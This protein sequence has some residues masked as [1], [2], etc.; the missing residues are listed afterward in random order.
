MK[1][2]F[3]VEFDQE[4]WDSLK[5]DSAQAGWVDDVRDAINEHAHVTDEKMCAP[6]VGNDVC[7]V[8]NVQGMQECVNADGSLC[9]TDHVGRSVTLMG[10]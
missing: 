4:V 3:T 5:W 1:V 6:N 8:C 10:N 9:Y 2:Q 7:P